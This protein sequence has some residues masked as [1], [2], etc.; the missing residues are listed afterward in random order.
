MN[1]CYQC[2]H[3]LELPGDA[4]IRC[5]NHEANVKGSDHGRRSGWFNWPLNFDPVWLESCDGFSDKPEDKKPRK[6]LDPLADL[7]GLLK[8]R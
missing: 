4:H 1:E 2:V 3:R 7:F 6:E 5:N 8:R